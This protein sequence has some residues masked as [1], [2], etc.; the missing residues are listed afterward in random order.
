MRSSI[1]SSSLRGTCTPP[2]PSMSV[3]F[4]LQASVRQ[5]RASSRASRCSPAFREQAGWK[6]RSAE[7]RGCAASGRDKPRK[8]SIQ[9][10]TSGAAGLPSS[11]GSQPVCTGLIARASKRFSGSLSSPYSSRARSRAAVTTVFPASVS[12]P[13]MTQPRGAAPAGVMS[14]PRCFPERADRERPAWRDL[15]QKRGPWWSGSLRS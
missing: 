5:A 13:V 6:Q 2:A 10:F 4:A 11:P 12:V 3:K 7:A 1:S 15:P 8:A 14:G 9:R